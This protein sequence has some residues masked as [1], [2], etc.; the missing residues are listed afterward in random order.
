VKPYDDLLAAIATLQ[1]QLAGVELVVDGQFS[2]PMAERVVHCVGSLGL[3]AEDL[4]HL[5]QGLS[6]HTPLEAP[7]TAN[8]PAW[9]EAEIRFLE[10]RLKQAKLNLYLSKLTPEQNA[11]ILA[12]G[13]RLAI[14]RALKGQKGKPN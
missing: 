6:Q 4:K 11:A 5:S 8:M 13:R 1:Q 10:E 14:K 12:E 9:H 3:A 7:Q 2:P